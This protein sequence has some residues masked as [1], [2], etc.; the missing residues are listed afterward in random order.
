MSQPHRLAAGGHVDRTRRVSFTFDGR[1][2]EGHPG[3]T[4]ASALLA[5]GVRLV[6]RSFKYH[7]P[8]GI[9]SAGVEEPNALVELRDGARREPNTRATVVELFDGLAATSQNRRG[10]LAFDWM[11]VNGLLAPWLGAG[12]YYKTF[13]WPAAYWERV[14]EP[15]IR[16]AAGLGRASGLP[17][18]DRYEAAHAHCD[19]LVV[20]AGAAGLA[21]ARAAGATGARVILA[22]QDALPGGDLLNEPGLEP[23]R[24]EALAAL[25]AMPEVTIMPRTTVFG[26]YD[27]GVLGAVERVAD[28]LPEP[29]PHTPR[30]R[31]WTIRAREVVLA[32]GAHERLIA[33][34]GNDRPGVMLAGAARSY[35]RRFGV[36]A[37]ENVALFAT[38][39]GAYD[40]AFAL[41]EAGARIAA[42]IDPRPDSPAMQRA[43]EAGFAVRAGSVVSATVGGTALRGIELRA[44]GGSGR[45]DA[46]AAD[47]LMI[48]GGW[49]P[50]VHLASMSGAALAWDEGL[51]AFVPGPPAQRER[52]AGACRGVHGI[53]AA[54][55]DGAA[56]GRAAAIAAGFAAAPDIALPDAPAPDHR[57]HPLWEVR[58]RG[59]AFVDIQDDVTADD[60]RLAHREGFSHIEHAKRYTTH[61]MG[62]D[63]GKTGGIVGA[64]VLAEA[65]G[66]PLAKVGLPRF[67]PYTSPIA[68]GAMA[69]E[70]VGAHFQPTR[71]TSLHAVHEAAGAVWMDAGIWKRPAYYPKREDADAW[72]SVL[73]E[74][75]AVRERVGI[76]DVSTLGKIAVEGPDAAIFLDRVYANTFSTLPVGRA[77]YGLMLREDGI[78][79]DDGTTSRIGPDR[80]FVT[81]TTAQAGPVMQHL[82]FHLASVW[83]ELDVSL[84]SITDQW[85]GIAIAGPKAREVIAGVVSGLD[86]SNEAFPF[87]AVA[88]CMAAGVPARLFRISFS[89]ELA[90]EIAMPA[91]YAAHVW[92]AAMAAGAPHGIEP[93]GMEALGLLRIE[94]G[95]VAGSELN[96][97]TTAQDLGLGRMLKK[98]G[99]FIGRVLAQRPGLTDPSRPRLVGLRS[100]DPRRQIRAGCHLLLPGGDGS[101][102]GWITSATQSVVDPGWIGLGLLR[103]G[104]ARIGSE[105]LAANPLMGEEV[106][107]KVI[108]PHMHD[109]ENLRVRA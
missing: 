20:G 27:Q 103:D 77:R 85:A 6:G 57:P 64:A 49:N 7:R 95:H 21:A 13:M 98:K 9:F 19:V 15:L 22:E 75:R 83:P 88:D 100:L 61:A 82:E 99:D 108:S 38:H 39:D 84:A 16:K 67:R 26:F 76:C 47:L 42:I 51:Q 66:E 70:G 102:Q 11:A 31:S 105:M 107:V 93:Y 58:G 55:A 12:F 101:S 41:A 96:G 92:Q 87:M 1:R 3:D 50:A 104:E 5:N 48:S 17:D 46:V 35:A 94:K 86:L 72:A 59:K 68:W 106:P 23:W 29:P 65:R 10:S 45:G 60:I 97:Q 69:G 33:F 71:R 14:Y 43:R 74:A 90:Y 81:T 62:T 4:L 37:G 78:V 56:A 63:Q 53:G 28:H 24:T 40:A 25:A 32:T 18:P 36:R 91:G 54:A 73:R 89:G 79:F 30:Q 109:P 52:S 80:F 8:R 34:P 2:Y 44:A